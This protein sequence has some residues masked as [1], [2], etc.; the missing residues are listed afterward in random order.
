M[1]LSNDTNTVQLQSITKHL[2]LMHPSVRKKRLVSFC[3]GL[4]EAPA[5]FADTRDKTYDAV[6]V[7]KIC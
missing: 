6:Y 3:F 7:C 2:G 4:Y 5:K 1:S